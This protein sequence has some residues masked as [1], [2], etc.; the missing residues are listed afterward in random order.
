MGILS[1]SAEARCT[2]SQSPG[3]AEPFSPGPADRLQAGGV[4][5]ESLGLVSLW[6]N[7]CWEI[8]LSQV[9]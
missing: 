4:R 3:E 2:G 1:Q 9:W 5:T 7:W 8:L 6:E